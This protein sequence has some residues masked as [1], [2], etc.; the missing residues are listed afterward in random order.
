[1]RLETII[2][3]VR[4]RKL[5]LLLVRGME[6]DDVSKCWEMLPKVSRSFALCIRVLPKPLD[7]Q[8]MLSYLIYRVIDTVEDSAAPLAAKGEI[9]GAFLGALSSRRMDCGKVAECKGRLCAEISCTYEAELLKNV[10]AVVR[11]YYSQPA[12]VRKCILKRGRTMAKGMY[13][14][15]K[16]GIETFAD[17]NNYSYYVAGVIGY[18][19]N[20]LLLYNGIITLELKRKLRRYARHFGLALQK[21]N[22][23]RDIAHDIAQNRRY[24]P[25]KL[26][27]KYKLSYESLCLRENREAAL[28][29]LHEQVKNAR[30]YLESAMKYVL[31]LPEK[32]LRVRMFCLIPLF[33]AIES[34]VKCAQSDIF[35]PAQKVKISRE[36]VRDI[37]A[38]SGLWGTSNDK[39]A[40][41]FS[42]SM[43]RVAG[44]GFEQE[45]SLLFNKV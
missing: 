23:L 45:Y 37:V 7:E 18:L 33:M 27:A 31:L 29:V 43:A 40:L 5:K 4:K 17:Q 1:M 16:K 22:I 10:D 38:K 32:A 12:E 41:W 26:I 20:D 13:G 19:F 9:F 2:N 30:R 14:F 36:E 25:K 3:Y 21:V 28:K 44:S 35:D 34:Y 42:Q 8:M 15:Q 24:W 11:A 39:L 6:M